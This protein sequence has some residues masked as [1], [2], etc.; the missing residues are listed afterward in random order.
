MA[1]NP[2]GLSLTLEL[3]Q[4]THNEVNASATQASKYLEWR[5]T[6]DGE[7]SA[8]TAEKEEAKNKL[9]QVQESLYKTLY[10]IIQ[11]YDEPYAS[12]LNMAIG[13]ALAMIVKYPTIGEGQDPKLSKDIQRLINVLKPIVTEAVNA[14]DE[15]EVTE[16]VDTGNENIS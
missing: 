2:H 13:K 14:V 11:S 12:A 6:R 15:N 4:T 7:V 1:T 10:Q 9:K 8:T 16:T 3:L 5:S